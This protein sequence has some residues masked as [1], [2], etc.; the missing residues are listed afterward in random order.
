MSLT[1]T[2]TAQKYAASTEPETLVWP[3]ASTGWH[4]RPRLKSFPPGTGQ[5][6]CCTKSRDTSIRKLLKCSGA[7]WEIRSRNSTKRSCEFASCWPIRQNRGLQRRK[8]NVREPNPQG[9]FLRHGICQLRAQL[10]PTLQACPNWQDRR[11]EPERT[12]AWAPRMYGINR[13]ERN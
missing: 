1:A 5:F 3:V 8:R 4:W 11:Y 12:K 10:C 13:M 7:L 9:H 6:S 2:A